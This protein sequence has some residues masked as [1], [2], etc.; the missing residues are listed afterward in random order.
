MH[1][2]LRDAD[3]HATCTR[4]LCKPESSLPYLLA[5]YSTQALLSN[6]MW[7]EDRSGLVLPPG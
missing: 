7:Q 1:V 4:M 2:G 6:G 3:M 5:P